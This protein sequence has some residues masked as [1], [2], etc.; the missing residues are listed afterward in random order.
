MQ[1]SRTVLQQLDESPLS[2]FHLKTVVTSGMGFFT[3]A[4][5]LFIIGVVISIL[6][7]IWHLSSLEVSLLGST[8][9]L[10]AALGSVIFGRLA[11]MLGRKFVYGYELL[12]LAVGAIVSALSPK[13]GTIARLCHDGPILR[14]AVPLPEL[15]DAHRPVSAGIRIEL[16]FHRIWSQCHNFCVS[17]RDFPCICPHNGPW[18]FSG[19]WQGGCISWCIRLPNPTQ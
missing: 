16:L 3:D 2:R 18:Y 1:S 4:Y 9:L 15:N 12:V 11:D 10:S 19:S 13:E 14:G 6:K 7:P 5:D 8:A 17:S